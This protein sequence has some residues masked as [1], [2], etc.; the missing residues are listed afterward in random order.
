[1]RQMRESEK[2]KIIIVSPPYSAQSGG[3]TVLYYLCKLLNEQGHEAKIFVFFGQSPLGFLFFLR[4]SRYYLRRFGVAILDFFT[5]KEKLLKEEK[6]SV[7][8]CSPFNNP[9]IIFPRLK[10]NTIVVYPEIVNGNPLKASNVVRWLLYKPGAHTGKVNY[11][12]N[13][14]FF[15]FQEIF[16]DDC[17]NPNKNMLQLIYLKRTIYK[18]QNYGLRYGNCY[19]IRKG[20]N[21]NDLPAV[22][23]GPVIDNLSDREIAKIFNQCKYCISYDQYTLYS[24]YAAMCGC[25]SVV[26]PMLGVEKEQWQ[27]NSELRHGIAYGL[28]LKEVQLA[29]KTRADMDKYFQKLEAENIE[30]VKHFVS[31]C[32]NYFDKA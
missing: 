18:Q 21:R 1:M 5:S 3:T 2:N 22:F 31:L 24:N 25:I 9:E 19:I 23:D 16:N 14:L 20:K 8:R 6:W 28:D 12:K 11:G 29:Q 17:L 27:P 4:K 13:D 15:S 30:Q 32:I 7:Y 26:M 10:N